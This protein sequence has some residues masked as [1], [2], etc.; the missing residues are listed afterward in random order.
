MR[1]FALLFTALCTTLATAGVTVTFG[2]LTVL[3][4]A[5]ASLSLNAVASD[6]TGFVFPERTGVRVDTPFH[7]NITAARKYGGHTRSFP[8]V[9]LRVGTV[10][11]TYLVHLDTIGSDYHYFKFGLRFDEEVLGI[12]IYAGSLIARD[13]L[14]GAPG[15]AY[16]PDPE[17]NRGL[18]LGQ[19]DWIGL[20]RERHQVEIRTGVKPKID[21]VRI[22][23]VGTVPEPASI[24]GLLAVGALAARRR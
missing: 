11:N 8:Y 17:F 7:P 22:Y 16:D 24:A 2:P 4:K 10:I 23:T 12:D 15:T 6:T 14:Y 21:E 3:D 9:D 20:R 19:G 5:P 1:A 13:A 18:E